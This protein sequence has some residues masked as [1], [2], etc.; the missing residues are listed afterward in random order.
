M[1]RECQ[2]CRMRFV[3]KRKEQRFCGYS[4]AGRGVAK[5]RGQIGIVD[6]ECGHCKKQFRAFAGNH[7]VYCSRECSGLARRTER[8]KCKICSKSCSGMHN[9]FCSKRCSNLARPRVLTSW[10]GFYGHAQRAHPEPMP[11]MRCGAPGEHRHH[12]DYSKPRDVEWVCAT[13][14]QHEHHLGIP[15]GTRVRPDEPPVIQISK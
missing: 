1:E 12:D 6:V 9:E 7:S 2:S 4:C 10:S 5:E 8:P 13:C 14:H 15:R 11:C 3:P